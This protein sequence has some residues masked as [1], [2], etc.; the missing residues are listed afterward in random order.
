MNRTLSGCRVRLHSAE[1]PFI[2]CGE[3]DKRDRDAE[4]GPTRY[5]L[6][7]VEV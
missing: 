1:T 6:R 2:R 3:G 5:F 4:D 7:H